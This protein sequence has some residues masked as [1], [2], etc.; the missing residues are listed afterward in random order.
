MSNTLT[1]ARMFPAFMSKLALLPTLTTIK[2]GLLGT[3]LTVLVLWIPVLIPCTTVFWLLA[4]M[5][6][7]S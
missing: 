3:T 6:A 1:V 7:A 4:V 5:V 2:F